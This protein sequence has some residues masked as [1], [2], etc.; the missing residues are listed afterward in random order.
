MADESKSS[1]AH[2]NQL[3][4]SNSR[5]CQIH[6]SPAY[7][8]GSFLRVTALSCTVN[9]GPSND[10][11]PRGVSCARITGT[12]ETEFI[13]GQGSGYRRLIDACRT[14]GYPEPEWREL[15]TAFQVTIFPHPAASEVPGTHGQG[16]RVPFVPFR[17][18]TSCPSRSHVLS[19]PALPISLYT[20]T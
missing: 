15:G 13:E 6:P 17:P 11:S 3:S 7:A 4:R 14:G 2:L 19:K 20:R 12:D 1:I 10:T 16:G 5:S 18:M 8:E 9:M